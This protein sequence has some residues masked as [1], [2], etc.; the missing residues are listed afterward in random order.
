MKTI[1][2]TIVAHFYNENDYWITNI[3][4]KSATEITRTDGHDTQTLKKKKP[5]HKN[6][7]YLPF[8]TG[9]DTSHLYLNQLELTEMGCMEQH[10]NYNNSRI[11]DLALAVVATRAQ[12]VYKFFKYRIVFIKDTEYFH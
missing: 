10:E 9:V 11:G 5:S 12:Q 3:Y 7:V 6:E 1:L 2:A 8:E 4:I